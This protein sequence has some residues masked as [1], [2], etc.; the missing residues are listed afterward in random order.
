VTEHARARRTVDV[1]IATYNVHRCRGMDRRTAP[2]RIADVLRE[3]DADVVA[4]QEVVGAGPAGAGQAE[5]IGAALGMGW[6]M[7][8]VRLLRRHQ[9]GNVVLSRL[10][11]LH[12][13]QYDLSWRT[14][15]PR[16]CQRADLDLGAGRLLHVYN[17]H[18]GTAVLERRY[19]ARRLA[20]Y[21][22]DRRVSEPKIIL[23]DFNEWLKGL[24]T[25]TLS[26]LFDSID[27]YAHLKRRR[28]YPGFFPMVHLDHIYY[29]G[30]V[31]VR[32]VQLLRSRTALLASDH[33][34]L[35]ADLRI[36]FD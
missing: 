2:A 20:S 18:L 28:T 19:Q 4:L 25:N 6:V 32:S 8:P 22:H 5:E 3:L 11:I 24:A 21:V 13:S 17:V 7:A 1:R 30:H 26:A 23:G 27:I 10:P 33:L 12:H 31:E 14:C 9:F 15:E 16:A 34:P 36:G 29:E 35:A